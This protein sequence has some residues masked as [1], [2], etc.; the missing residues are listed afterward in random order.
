MS[1]T[2]ALR[3]FWT[4]STLDE[5]KHARVTVPPQP[6]TWTD[7]HQAR[8]VDLLFAPV[9]LAP[10]SRVLDYGCGVGRVARQ[11]ARRGCGVIAVDVAEQMLAHCREYCAGLGGI[12]YVLSDGYGVRGAADA[13]VDGVYSF[14]VFQHMPCLDMARSVLADLYRVLRPGGWCVLQTVDTRSAEPVTRVGFHGARQ[15]PAWLIQT[16]RDLGFRRLELR[17]DAEPGF[18]LLMLAAF[19]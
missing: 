3:E 14:Y 4:V 10:G 15:T 8:V 17:V 5:A 18:D 11:L 7:A 12:E 13:W 9:P 2:Q 6:E 16:A 19:K 1:F